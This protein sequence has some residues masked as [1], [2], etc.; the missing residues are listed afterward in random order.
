MGANLEEKRFLTIREYCTITG[1]SSAKAARDIK[2][3]RLP[4]IKLGSRRLVP[5]AFL[6]GL[7]AQALASVE[8]R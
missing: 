5:G 7:E 2:S 3:G 1:T 6:D 4:T 8:A